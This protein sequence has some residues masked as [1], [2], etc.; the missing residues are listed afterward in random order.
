MIN[1]QDFSC[2]IR[3]CKNPFDLA[4]AIVDVLE[5]RLIARLN[6]LEPKPFGLA[7]GRTMEP[8][9]QALVSRLRAWPMQ[10]LQKLREGWSSFNLD[11]YLGLSKIDKESFSS[12]MDRHLGTPLELAP[13]KLLIP[14]RCSD[15][16]AKEADLYIKHLKSLGGLSFQLLGLGMNGHIG[17]NEPPCSSDVPCR[18]VDLSLSTRQQNAF[19][20]RGELSRV[21]THAITLGLSE[22]LLAE[23]VH[24]V[25]T[26]E[27][28]S[29]IL[30]SFLHEPISELLPASWLR[31]H[32]NLFVWA[33]YSAFS[34][35]SLVKDM[36]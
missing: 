36:S 16:P 5:D 18:V 4:E 2:K 6:Q 21:P 27:A 19:S 8:I 20:F 13:D 23:E 1:S 25:V 34:K 10:D 14:D 28:K 26:G 7:T 29:Q 3:L 24:L 35:V 17:F 30:Y 33:D 12:Y 11:E 15:D 31:H 9:Y 22:I 32:K